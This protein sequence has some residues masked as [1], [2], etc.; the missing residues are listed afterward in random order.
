MGKN[1]RTVS[2]KCFD[3]FTLQ[4]LEMVVPQRSPIIAQMIAYFP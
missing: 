3:N 2:V 4:F 1:L